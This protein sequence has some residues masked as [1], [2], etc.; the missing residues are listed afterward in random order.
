VTSPKQ[1]THWF[2]RRLGAALMRVRPAPV[3]VALKR[4]LGVQRIE[5]PTAEGTFWLDPA[6]EFG[7]RLLTI[8]SC[9]PELVATMRRLLRPGDIFADIGANEGYFSVVGARLVGQ[10]GRV[11]AVEP[12]LRLQEVLRR[13]FALNDAADVILVRSAVSDSAGVAQLNLAPSMNTGAT[14]LMRRTRYALERETVPLRTLADIVAQTG[15][16]RIDLLKMDIEGWEYEAILGSPALFTSGAIR[17]ISL[18]LHPD[19]LRDRGLDA[20]R[21]VDFLVGCGYRHAAD[22]ETIVFLRTDASS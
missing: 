6:S 8:G 4:L 21:I 18:E 10:K 5:F 3:A 7:Q 2:A 20:Q 16:D 17:A 15:L 1:Q 19:H 13:N 12:Q 9:E 11:L 22:F 14:S